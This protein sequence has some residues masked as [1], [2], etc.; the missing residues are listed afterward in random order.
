MD[1]CYACA[2][3]PSGSSK[4][5]DEHIIPQ[6]L[7]GRKALPILC[8]LHNSY[9]GLKIDP[10][11]LSVFQ[12]FRVQLGL[13]QQTLDKPKPW[14]GLS[15]KLST[16]GKEFLMNSVGDIFLS[17]PEFEKQDLGNGKLQIKIK[18]ST[19]KEKNILLNQLQKKYPKM[20]YGDF[21]PD[22]GEIDPTAQYMV[23]VN[24][25]GDP[26]KKAVAK[27]AIG[28]VISAGITAETMSSAIRY[29]F[30]N[31][32]GNF[33]SH[34]DDF[35]T[36]QIKKGSFNHTIILH[37]SPATGLLV[38]FIEFFGCSPFMI[39][40]SDKYAGADICKSYT[41]D[42]TNYVE[43]IATPTIDLTK[44]NFYHF[45]K[46]DDLVPNGFI[47]CFKFGI[48]AASYRQVQNREISKVVDAAYAELDLKGKDLGQV[49]LIKISEFVFDKYIMPKKLK[50]NLELQEALKI[51]KSNYNDDEGK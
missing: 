20:S 51:R 29:C 1:K 26:L 50:H 47:E 6:L 18:A 28:F 21:K 9:A 4:I 23:E 30:E 22:N 10:G 42:P 3:I 5:T 49:E 27:V 12:P 2:I 24:L 44:E 46:H 35:L 38:S 45:F 36:E 15:V 19:E 39:L 40:L 43:E 8:D 7:G 31:E 25:S 17:K 16:T 37:G 48:A 41:I 14:T 34:L 33:V 32:S 11:F 13:V